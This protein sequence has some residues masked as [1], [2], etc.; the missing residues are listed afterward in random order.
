MCR[1]ESG[2]VD[3]RPKPGRRLKPRR[4]GFHHA[5]TEFGEW[6][7]DTVIVVGEAECGL[8]APTGE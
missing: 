1:G 2:A 4:R 5:M 7:V 3:Q 8:A 6:G